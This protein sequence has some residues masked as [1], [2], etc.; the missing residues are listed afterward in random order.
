MRGFFF[1]PNT[2]LAESIRNLLDHAIANHVEGAENLKAA[3]EVAAAS[4]A[5]PSDESECSCCGCCEPVEF[6]KFRTLLK[7]DTPGFT[8]E[9]LSAYI[10][11]E[12]GRDVI[13]VNACNKYRELHEVYTLTVKDGFRV[14]RDTIKGQLK[15]GVLKVTGRTYKS[16]TPMDEMDL[17]DK[18]IP[19][20]MA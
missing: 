13:V 14:D 1:M 10:H 11:S 20:V 16:K 17:S 12:G 2:A 18:A 6:N 4:R 19:I 7:A 5:I 8:N 3:L 15:L 9:S